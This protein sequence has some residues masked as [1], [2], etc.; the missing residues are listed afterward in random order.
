LGNAL[1]QL[2]NANI[3]GQA[4]RAHG[5]VHTTI[6]ASNR[7]CSCA[8]RAKDDER[9]PNANNQQRL[10]LTFLTCQSD[11]FCLSRQKSGKLLN[12][13]MI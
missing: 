13:N 7:P 4:T 9:L 5:T 8:D 11:E 2:G 3:T 12:R 10:F 6:V 1:F